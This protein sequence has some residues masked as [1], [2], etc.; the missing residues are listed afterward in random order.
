MVATV[1]AV[2]GLVLTSGEEV[3]GVHPKSVLARAADGSSRT[4]HR[5][6]APT[7]SLQEALQLGWEPTEAEI[8]RVRDAYEASRDAALALL[9]APRR[10]VVYG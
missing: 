8:A 6:D 10:A 3:V 4:L 5:A 2:V 1:P 7:V 9:K